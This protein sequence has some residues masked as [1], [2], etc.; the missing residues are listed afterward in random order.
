MPAITWFHEVLGHPGINCLLSALHR[1]YHP[2]LYNLVS[3]FRCKACQR[4]KVGEQ[5]WGHLAGRE[6]ITSSWEQV[7]VDLI[8]P[9]KITMS[10]NRTYEFL[11][12]T[13]VDRVTGLAELIRIDNKESAHVAN[14]FAEQWLARYP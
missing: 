6:V 12:L 9:W 7:E 14:K 2:N 10:T 3:S 5:G 4:H 1:Y 13:C 11:A 8:G